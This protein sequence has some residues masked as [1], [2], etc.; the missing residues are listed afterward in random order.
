MGQSISDIQE[1]VE[2]LSLNINR[3]IGVEILMLGGP[4]AQVVICSLHE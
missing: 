3:E 1:M 4:S 2:Y